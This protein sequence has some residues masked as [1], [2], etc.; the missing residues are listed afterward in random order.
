MP[1]PEKMQSAVSFS[2][3]GRTWSEPKKI[4]DPGFPFWRVNWNQRENAAYG[5]TQKI[6]PGS[7]AR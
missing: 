6:A 4:G 7:G 1:T 3:D 5:Y 2:D